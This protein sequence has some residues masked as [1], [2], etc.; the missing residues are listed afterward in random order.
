MSTGHLF[1]E[2]GGYKVEQDQHLRYLDNTVVRCKQGLSI[3]DRCQHNYDWNERIYL[4]KMKID[5]RPAWQYL[6]VEDEDKFLEHKLLGSHIS[7]LASG[8]GQDPPEDVQNEMKQWRVR[9][10]RT[11]PSPSPSP[12][13]RSRHQSTSDFPGIAFFADSVSQRITSQGATMQLP[14]AGISL[15]VPEQAL[16]STEPDVDLLIRPC[17]GGPFELPAGYEPASPAY[18]IQPDKKVKLQREAT[19]VIRHYTRLQSKEDCEEMAFFSA[20]PTPEYRQS[21]PVYIFKEI[22]SKGVFIPG[23]QLGEIKLK[24][25]CFKIIGRKRKSESQ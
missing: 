13:P 19:L 2:Y 23:S 12:S 21:V 20:T 17:L 3:R 11:S 4:V 7:V 24:H 1:Q 6:S 10:H 14:H 8:L 18:L 25:F 9:K 16:S 5:G 22:K 15:S